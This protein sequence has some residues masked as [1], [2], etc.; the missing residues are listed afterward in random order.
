MIRAI[1]FDLDDT[2]CDYAGARARG[3]DAAAALLVQ[4]AAR[5]QFIARY[6]EA[7]PRLFRAFANREIDLETYRRRRFAEAAPREPAD[8][9]LKRANDAYMSEANGRATLFPD[10]L[11]TLSTLAD[12]G[13]VLALLTNGPS[14]GQRVKLEA[15]GLLKAFDHLFISEEIGA[16]KPSR[17]A[18]ARVARALGVSPA[19]CL[20]VG[21]ALDVDIVGARAAG[22]QAIHLRRGALEDASGDEIRS[23]DELPARLA[24]GAGA[25]I[26]RSELR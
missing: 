3:L 4:P 15:S 18:F 2:L 21:D 11:R 6:L 5:E 20:M 1:I 14:D 16:A 26:A 13:Y 10:A 12:R 8:E 23:L 7:E 25:Q 22:M 24:D 17:E 19:E 9:T